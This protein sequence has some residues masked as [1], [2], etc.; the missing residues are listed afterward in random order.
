MPTGKGPLRIA[1]ED[2]LT[3]FGFGNKVHEWVT[4]Q[5][6]KWETE[7]IDTFDEITTALQIQDQLPPQLKPAALRQLIKHQIGLI[8]VIL[9]AVWEV[10][11]KFV[12]FVSVPALR[13]IQRIAE[14][15]LK[16][17]H[18]DIGVLAQM[19]RKYPEGN[20]NY[21][22]LMSEEGYAKPFQEAFDRLTQQFL[23]AADYERLFL[24]GGIS[25]SELNKQLRILGYEEQEIQAL[26]ELRS[27]IP[28]P[29]DLINM[30][31]REAFNDEFSTR[32]RHDEGDTTQVT[33]W[34]AK[35]GLSE[36]WVKRFW[37]AHWQLP[38]ANQVFEMLHRLRP[39]TTENPIEAADVDAFLKAA[40]YSPFWRDRLKEISYLPFSRVDIRRMYK[41]G[42]L[43]QAQVKEAYLDAGYDDKRAQA[44]TEFT[45]A[46]EAEEESGI[47]RSS[48]ISAYGD[49]QIDRSTAEKM[50]SS[51][52]YD[53]TT[54]SFYLDNVDFKQSLEIQ[55]I[56]VQA[57]HKKF[58][59][60]LID[61]TSVHTALGPLNLPSERVTAMLELWL[62]ERENKTELLSIS[63][64]EVLLERGI[65]TADD[66]KRIAQRRGYTDETIQ[67]TL[68]RIAQE[69]A[70]RA[71]KDAEKLAA[72]NERIQKSKTSSAYQKAKSE[73]DL[74]IAQARAEITD[75]DVAL[76]GQ[77]EDAQAVELHARKDELKLFI[78]QMNVK[79]AQ[80]RYDNNTALTTLGG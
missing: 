7:A 58:V 63:Q 53:T 13:P 42:I 8:A 36:E 14:G 74:A 4:H 51:G 19:K 21:D 39:G 57:I 6:E 3:G 28:N 16:T 25:E 9:P 31:V 48:V 72:D 12:E 55:N 79:K 30:Q 20:F 1:I 71:Q 65:V 49:G 47:V 29:N 59:E 41:M 11:Q 75:I 5:L 10:V 40:D 44:L 17:K 34:A 69:A 52:G 18:P 32:F 43:T 70:E 77:V 2:F 66:Y 46:F 15:V 73:V 35:Q 76:H 33:E 54:I 27:V 38:G 22:I 80:L 23:N 67:W 64:M 60:G 24:R 50:L 61:E 56:K 62:T 68:T 37:R 78:A 26:A 45:V